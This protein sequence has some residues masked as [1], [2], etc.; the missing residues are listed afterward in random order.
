MKTYLTD[1][2]GNEFT[3][4]GP[5]KIFISAPTGMGKT[6]F[7]VETLLPWL[8]YW[9]KR[10]SRCSGLPQRKML[11]LCNRTLLRQ[12]YLNDVIQKFDTYL[13]LVES[14]EVRTYQ[15]LA[16]ELRKNG[17][18]SLGEYS[19]I[20]CDECHYFYADSDFNGFG[21][22]MLLQALIME[23][24]QHQMIF[25]SATM[26]LVEDKIKRIICQCYVKQHSYHKDKAKKEAEDPEGYWD[27]QNILYPETLREFKDYHL[28]HLAKYDRFHCICVPDE[29]TLCDSLAVAEGKS[30]I[31]IDNKKAAE[32]M[33]DRM[34]R[35][36]GVPRDQIKIFN[37]QNLDEDIN[38][39]VIEQMVICHKLLPKIL[40]TTS[41]LD[42]GVSIQD[43][44]V[45]NVAIITE[46]KISF[47]QMLGRIRSGYADKINLFWMKREA[48]VFKIREQR[49]Q[50]AYDMY[51]ESDKMPLGRTVSI[52][53]EEPETEKAK[54]YRQAFI[55]CPPE[56]AEINYYPKD[57]DIKYPAR[58]EGTL[59]VTVKRVPTRIEDISLVLNSFGMEKTGDMLLIEKQFANLAVADP[60]KVVYAQMGWIKKRPEQ[61]E[62]RNSTMEEQM[63]SELREKLLGVRNWTNEALQSL[64]TE[65]AKRY[66]KMILSEYL[67]KDG[68][69]SKDKLEQICKACGLKLVCSTDENQKVRYTIIED[70]EPEEEGV[71]E[72]AVDGQG[73]AGTVTYRQGQGICADARE[74]VSIH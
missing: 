2:I 65:V 71:E 3:E 8:Q 69:F 15:D 19:T 41:V 55:V 18:L 52:C 47:I 22:Y 14:V 67:S 64:K 28:N 20:C 60:L 61:L 5:R 1:A 26:E 56:V 10:H 33:A 68:S 51:K 24:I 32:R 39:Q 6:T 21:T 31:F 59:R 34:M 44:D 66:R 9:E 62:I 70:F 48:D 27:E 63:W 36:G 29:E 53:W 42:N 11:I 43:P 54:I 37:A 13:D 25:M 45:E 73:T 40:I 16:C 46:S 38:D 12:Q 4:W 30:I 50:A 35:V 57:Q 58:D 74:S 49:C 7:I 17:K 72:H 23:G